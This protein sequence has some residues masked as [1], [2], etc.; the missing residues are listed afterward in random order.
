M[1]EQ[2]MFKSLMR[3][4]KNFKVMEI[5]NWEDELE[6]KVDFG[7]FTYS[8]QDANFIH[9]MLIVVYLENKIEI[10]FI[11]QQKGNEELEEIKTKVY[12]LLM[13]RVK[14]SETYQEHEIVDTVDRERFK[15]YILQNERL[16]KKMERY[17]K[18]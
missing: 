11:Q 12:N 2:T 4:H 9:V 10:E 16:Q 7:Y 8:N 6:E 5:K 13:Q 1:L 14:E 3:K 17:I 15:K 18:E